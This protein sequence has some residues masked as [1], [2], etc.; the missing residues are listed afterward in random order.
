MKTIYIV[1]NVSAQDIIKNIIDK[2]DIKSYQIFE[3]V[4]SINPIA[5]PRLNTAI[6]PGY[7]SAFMIQTES[8]NQYVELVDDLKT[9]NDNCFNKAER[10]TVSVW[11]TTDF[12]F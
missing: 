10:I 11:D 3:Q 8:N 2:K 7:S 1:C 12:F 4:L 5:Q 9:Y 6:W